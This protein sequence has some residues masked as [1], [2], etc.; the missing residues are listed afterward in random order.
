M[1]KNDGWREATEDEPCPIC[2][3]EHFCMIGRV[4]VL[5]TQL[6]S[7]KPS[8]AGFGWWH[9]YPNSAERPTFIPKPKP[10]RITDA[11]LHAKWEPIL[12]SCKGMVKVAELAAE[13]GVDHWSLEALGFAWDSTQYIIPTRNH[14]GLITGLD[15]RWKD[16]T[17]MVVP[18]SRRGLIYAKNWLDYTGPVL[19]VEGA[20]DAAAALTMRLCVLGRPSNIGGVELLTRMLGNVQRR[21]IV[22]AERDRK[23]HEDLS[24]MVRKQHDPACKG[25]LRCWP[26]M[27]GAKHTANAL[28]KRLGRRVDWAFVPAPAKDMRG[29]LNAQKINVNNERACIRLGQSLLRRIR[30]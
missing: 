6:E 8:K 15:T 21:I 24:E 25:C 4:S 9:S 20:S 10:P 14:R 16:G 29:W 19:I 5:C 18:G 30:P 7:P 27:G 13:L 1:R 12:K 22:I 28:W 2:G 11:E 26:G 23:R 3:R 17:K